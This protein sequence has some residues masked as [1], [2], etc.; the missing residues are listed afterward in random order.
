MQTPALQP[1]TSEQLI[2]RI[3]ADALRIAMTEITK[4][5]LESGGLLLGPIGS[6]DITEF[7]YDNGG[8]CTGASYT[9][10]HVTLNRLM[11]QQWIPGGL[12]MKGFI[13]SH[14]TGCDALSCGDLRYI[15]R[16]LK[17]N[18]DMDVFAAP[19]VIPAEYRL[20]P[21]VVQRSNPSIPQLAQLTVF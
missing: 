15:Q 11:K 19:I 3:A 13:H 5:P 6:N 21:F 10:D 4:R 12:D 16:L 14:P 2:L 8:T 1:P 20:C 9:P 17:S 18:D 7:F